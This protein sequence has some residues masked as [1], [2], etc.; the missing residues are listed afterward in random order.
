MK[1][2]NEIEK[3]NTIE[4]NKYN[5]INPRYQRSNKKRQ[6]L[7]YD[8]KSLEM[9]K[10][11]IA[12]NKLKEKNNNELN[13]EDNNDNN[14]SNDSKNKSIKLNKSDNSKDSNDLEKLKNNYIEKIKNRA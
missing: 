5:S 14:I 2:S 3:P 12:L 10:E 6:N 8:R 1:M 11:E 4:E 9:M 13:I 7:R